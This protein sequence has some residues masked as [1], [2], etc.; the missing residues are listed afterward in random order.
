MC[1]PNMRRRAR[2]L[3]LLFGRERAALV[4]I[5]AAGLRPPRA[6]LSSAHLRLLVAAACMWGRGGGRGRARR[7]S[8]R[9]SAL[10]PTLLVIL[11]TLGASKQSLASHTILAS[12]FER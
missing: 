1:G 12:T 3:G 7:G 4:D 9:T 10:G 5:D 8:G 2:H 11:V 6:A